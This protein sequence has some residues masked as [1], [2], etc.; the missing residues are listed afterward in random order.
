MLW[1]GVRVERLAEAERGRA[2]AW[3]AWVEGLSAGTGTGGAA[4][5]VEPIKTDD[6]GASSVFAA[7][8]LGRSVI[9]KRRDLRTIQQRLKMMLRVGRGW[10][11][12]RGAELLRA[13]GVPTAEPVALMTEWRRPWPVEWL[14]LE[15]LP[16]KT[17]LRHMAEGD[18]SVR[19]EHAVARAVGRLVARTV[20]A[21]LTNRDG[22]PSNV[23]IT[24]VAGGE[25]EAAFIDTV[26]VRRM[27]LSP[28][29]TGV[30][31]KNLVVEALGCGVLPR[32]SLLMRAYAWDGPRPGAE[33]IAALG[34]EA[35]RAEWRGV[36]DAEW[37]MV[38]E[39][40]RRHGDPRPRV[41]PLGGVDELTS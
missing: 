25:A 35:A 10:R 15:R 28:P 37:A 17:L 40:V 32:R 8:A 1:S 19:E 33:D 13:G 27:R 36:R 20:E 3:G 31:L 26:G 4:G 41:D 29:A 11:Q 12:W 6:G 30:M 16:G 18:L 38:E 23:M 5:P 34:E 14:V 24:R 2:R 7:E 22:K 21:G 9:V 39:L